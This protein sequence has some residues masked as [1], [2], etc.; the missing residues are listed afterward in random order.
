MS[1]STLENSADCW[2]PGSDSF[3]RHQHWSKFPAPHNCK[4]KQLP[5][6]WPCIVQCSH[7]HSSLLLKVKVV[8]GSS[9]SLRTELQTVNTGLQWWGHYNTTP[10]WSLLVTG[11]M[12][13]PGTNSYLTLIIFFREILFQYFFSVFNIKGHEMV[14]H[15]Y[16]VITD[17]MF[18]VPGA[19]P[20]TVMAK[21]HFTS[22]LTLIL[23]HLFVFNAVKISITSPSVI[24]S[25]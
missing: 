13:Q 9:L 8:A 2:E 19:N 16:N 10:G 3:Y 17:P 7:A 6:A 21:L 20:E 14:Y 5:P 23:L 11:T 22:L 18:I 12:Q 24:E 25:Q 1:T 4:L 15:C